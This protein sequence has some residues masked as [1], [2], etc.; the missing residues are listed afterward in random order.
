[1]KG[2][3]LDINGENVKGAISEGITSIILTCKDDQYNINF[4]SLD[5]TGMLAYTWLFSEL[6]QGSKLKISI[7]EISE[8]L[9]PTSVTDYANKDQIDKLELESYYRMRDDLIKEGLIGDLGK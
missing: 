1:M 9:E 2:F 8:T 3:E 4:S 5:N 7:S 6:E